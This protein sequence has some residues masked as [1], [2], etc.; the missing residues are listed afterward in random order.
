[1][2]FDEMFMAGT[3]TEIIP[4]LLVDGKPVGNG[5]VGPVTIALR[6]AFL[7]YLNHWLSHPDE[8]VDGDFSD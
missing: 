4:I 6:K 3:T 1:M 7:D 5:T 8:D 2:E